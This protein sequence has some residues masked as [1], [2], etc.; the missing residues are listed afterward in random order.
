MKKVLEIN[1]NSVENDFQMRDINAKVGVTF[2]NEGNLF[3]LF[4]KAFPS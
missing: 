4:Q 3:N 2:Q 1:A